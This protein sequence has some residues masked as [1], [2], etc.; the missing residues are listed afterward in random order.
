MSSLVHFLF[1]F[2][3]LVSTSITAGKAPEDCST[4]FYDTIIHVWPVEKQETL[5]GRVPHS[6][7]PEMRENTCHAGLR[8]K[9][10]KVV[11]GRQCCDGGQRRAGDGAGTGEPWSELLLWFLEGE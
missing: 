5:W 1:S 7:F 9:A 6:Q 8:G 10:W 11:A 2:L 3:G 4:F